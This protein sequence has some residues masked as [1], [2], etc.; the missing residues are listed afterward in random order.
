MKQKIQGEKLDKKKSKRKKDGIFYTPKYITNNI[1]ENTI[2]TLCMEKRKEFGILE[3]ELNDNFKRKDGKL[4]KKGNEIFNKLQK[5]KKWIF[6]LKILDPACGSGA[7][8]NQALQFLIKEHKEID[9]MMAEITQKS[10]RIHDTDKSILEQNLFGVDIN[11]ESV[12]IAKLSLWLRTAKKGR[13]LSSLNKNI[14]CG[15]SLIDDPKIARENAFNWNMEFKEI[16][17]N[18]GFDV[19]VGNPPYGAK[20]LKKEQKFLN[21]NYIKGASETAIS[22]L[23]LSNDLLK[24]KKMASFIIPNWIILNSKLINWYAYR[25]IFGKAVR[26][27]HFCNPTTSKIPIKEISKKYKKPFIEKADLMLFLNYKLQKNLRNF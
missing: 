26:T 17:K 22:F 23:K 9:D 8:L 16:M 21:E 18:G 1:I 3:I 11:E 12:E 5:Y 24:N 4:N 25:F 27:M 6:N 13:K 2:G 19:I 20:I 14:K 15:N 10:L 7:F